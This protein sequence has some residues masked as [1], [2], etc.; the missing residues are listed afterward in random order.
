VQ[1]RA[2]EAP[3]IHEDNRVACEVS[4]GIDMMRMTD[5]GAYQAIDRGDKALYRAKARGRNRI[6][7]Y[8]D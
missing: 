7:I 3:L 4:I 1:R 2:A 8:Y 6:E 5:D